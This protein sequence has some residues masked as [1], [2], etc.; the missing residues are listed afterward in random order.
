MDYHKRLRPAIRHLERHYNQPL[1]LAE[2]AELAALSPYHFQRI[3]KA[4]TGETPSEYLR[5]LRLE[6]IAR[7][8]FY[9]SGASI[10]ALAL[11]HGFSSSQALAK[12]FHRHFGLAPSAIR[13]CTDLESIIRTMHDSKIGHQLRK[14]GNARGHENPYPENA[15][16]GSETSRNTIMKIENHPPRT[17]A[18]IR[19]T[20][21][22]GENYET[23]T[24][25][26]Y[27]W[28]D[29]HG[30]ADGECLFIYLDNPETTPQDKCRTDIC[31]TVPDNAPT[32]GDIEK[33]HIPGG[34]YAVLR[35]T[36]TDPA[37]YNQY[38][39]EAIDAI[40]NA[41]IAIDNDRPCYEL[42]HSFDSATGTADVNFCTAVENG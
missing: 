15:S 13:A 39:Q 18:C 1:Q 31:L 27:Q 26:L 7:R 38:W 12:A 34:C 16:T 20:G 11:E 23:P 28:A 14:P 4:V 21:A 42:Y 10:T 8:L 5:R 3:F 25:R 41:G 17:L 37:Q 33:Q 35:R 32:G 30:L 36:V 6:N 29:M 24:D 2:M 9:D 22:Y 19:V 40:I